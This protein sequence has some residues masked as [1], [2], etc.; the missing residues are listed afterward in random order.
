MTTVERILQNIDLLEY[1]RYCGYTPY[2]VGS[3]CYGLREHSSVRIYPESNTYFHASRDSRRLNVI[4]F[5]AWYHGTDNK[6]A[7]KR[8]AEELNLK[9][10]YSYKE[11]K[12]PKPPTLEKENIPFALPEKHKGKYS[13]VYAYLNKERCIDTSI[14]A[15]FMKNDLLYQDKNGNAAFVGKDESG[16]AVFCFERG[17]VPAKPYKHIVA[18]SDFS[19]AFT[20]CNNA[21]KL[22]I[23]EAIIDSMSIMTMLKEAGFDYKEYDYIA[24]CGTSQAA[25]YKHLENHPNIK[26]VYLAFDKDT[27]GNRCRAKTGEKLADNKDIRLIDKKPRNKDWNEDLQNLN[28]YQNQTQNI[29]KNNTIERSI[30]R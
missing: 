30:T 21:S 26:T 13:R 22:F 23:T 28:K 12:K 29:N 17:T 16:K 5:Y 15:D 6:E 27:A 18:G 19:T 8:L 14:I 4:N 9:P 10:E 11:P 7:I 2:K 24:T 3:N 20:I 1:M 25:V